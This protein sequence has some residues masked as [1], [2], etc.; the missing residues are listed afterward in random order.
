MDL[1]PLDKIATLAAFLGGLGVLWFA[2]LRHRGGLAAHLHRGRRLR[3]QEALSI[4]PAGRAMILEEDGRDILVV[5]IK[6]SG[7][8]LHPLDPILPAPGVTGGAA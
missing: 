7:L 6:G 4:G 3:L 1:L 8:A 2:V 5:Q